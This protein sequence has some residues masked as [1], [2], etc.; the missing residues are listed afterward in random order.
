[1]RDE[2]RNDDTYPCR[3]CQGGILRLQYHT[4][5]TWLNDVMVTVP[6]FPIWVCDACGYREEDARAHRWL[7][8]LLNPHLGQPVNK[9]HKANNGRRS[10]SPRRPN[11]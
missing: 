8:V 1:M 2:S 11:W 6:D 9:N 3:N 7:G 4:H 10:S 5:F